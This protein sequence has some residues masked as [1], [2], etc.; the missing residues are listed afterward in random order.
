M[1]KMFRE[2]L[3]RSFDV[4]DLPYKRIKEM[5]QE[6]KNSILIDVRSKQE[7]AEGHLAN[8]INI[9]L[10]EIEFQNDK[11]P[12]NKQNTIIVYCASGHRSRQAKEKLEKMGYTNV[13]S[14]KNGLDGM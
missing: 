9:P 3:Y 7:Y 1:F 13:Y 14:L 5:L 6:D 11:L 8:S 4:R 12:K 2:I 10:Y